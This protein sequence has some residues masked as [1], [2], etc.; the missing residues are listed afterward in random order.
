MLL[1]HSFSSFAQL[2]LTGFSVEALWRH[3]VLTGQLAR[4]IAQGEETTSE[5]IDQAFTAGLL[6]DIGK[7]LVGANLP[8]AFGQ[9]LML[10]RRIN[11]STWEA[12]NQLMAGASHAEL[13]GCVLGIWKLPRPVVEAVALHHCPGRLIDHAFSPLTAVH[14]ANVLAHEAQPD[15]SATMPSKLDMDY[16]TGLGLDE[17]LEHWRE[18]CLA[19]EDINF[20]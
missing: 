15:D 4:R 8:A 7:L 3:S 10:A 9:V 18:R 14:V 11:C 5:T 19:T 13:G 6:H 2:E 12:E 16:L 20:S 17:R 1:A